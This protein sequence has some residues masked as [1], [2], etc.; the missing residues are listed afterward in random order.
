MTQAAEKRDVAG[1]HIREEEVLGLA[2]KYRT[3]TEEMWAL[4]R[5]MAQ[6]SIWKELGTMHHECVICGT[7]IEGTRRF[8]G[9]RPTN[10]NFGRTSHGKKHARDGSAIDRWGGADGV[11]VMPSRAQVVAEIERK[12]KQRRVDRVLPALRQERKPLVNDRRLQRHA[13]EAAENALI[14]QVRKHG[15]RAME[16]TAVMNQV[17]DI[18]SRSRE[19]ERLDVEIEA[20]EKTFPA[21]VVGQ[22]TGGD[23]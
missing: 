17:S 12:I 8:T 4:V 7:V 9:G 14:A 21:E 6:A 22:L 11:F 10:T 15:L 5:E 18:E 13:R 3:T 19:I 23:L 1:E 16:F 2:N 20:I